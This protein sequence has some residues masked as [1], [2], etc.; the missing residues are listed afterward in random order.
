MN[1]LNII[2]IGGNVIEDSKL[3]DSFLNDFAS[4]KEYKIL[5]HGGGKDASKLAK[6]LGVNTNIIDGRRITDSSNLEIIT[7]VY[8]GKINKFIVAKLQGL[9]CNAIGVSGADCNSIT[10]VK[11]PIKEIDYG[12]VGDIDKIN[13]NIFKLLLE[14]KITPVCCAISHDGKG[15]LL[16]TNA[17]TIAS[18]LAIELSKL[19]SVSLLYCFE[20]KGVLNIEKS[21]QKILELIT[22][23]SYINL[24]SKG[25]INSG[26][27]PKIDNCFNALK[28]GVKIVK[29]GSPKI[30][31]GNEP[32]TKVVL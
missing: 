26:M 21:D 15:Q 28:S 17:D 4:I 11:R 23:T 12:F 29:I 18:V 24:K 25:V 32:H 19:Y 13:T 30:I 22:P 2:K 7:M 10:A 9:N 20:K 31:K 1:K 14:N 3:L 6:K 5:V 8:G 16:N 27:I